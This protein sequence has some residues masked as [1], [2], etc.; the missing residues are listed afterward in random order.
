LG[1]L[2]F[3]IRVYLERVFLAAYGHVSPCLA[4]SK[5][6]SAQDPEEAGAGNKERLHGCFLPRDANVP[7]IALA[8]KKFNPSYPNLLADQE[9]IRRIGKIAR[10]ENRQGFPGHPSRFRLRN[11]IE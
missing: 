5:Q 6:Q 8:T 9:K 4:D 3:P 1:H 2:S 10:P 11:N 7:E